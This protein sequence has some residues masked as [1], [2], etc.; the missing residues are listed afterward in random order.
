MKDIKGYIKDR[1]G[2]DA[3]INFILPDQVS[4]SKEPFADFYY[5]D[6]EGN[7]LDTLI[8]ERGDP[9]PFFILLEMFEC[10]KSNQKQYKD[11]ITIDKDKDS[12]KPIFSNLLYRDTMPRHIEVPNNKED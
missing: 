1:Y 5:V 4:N 11:C 10:I 12:L 3:M 8:V 6:S 9:L 2:I 7:K